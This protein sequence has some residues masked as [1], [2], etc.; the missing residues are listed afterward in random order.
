M[1]ARRILVIEDD[2]A[3]RQGVVDALDFQGFKTLEA[4]R[5]DTGLEL[6][7]TADVDLVLLDLVLP[8]WKSYLPLAVA[9]VTRL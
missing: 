6:A 1:S 3:I 9:S 7:V 8:P 4:G 2:P 5:G